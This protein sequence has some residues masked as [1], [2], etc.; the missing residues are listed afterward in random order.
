MQIAY[1]D[2]DRTP[3]LYLLKEAASKHEGLE[4]EFVQVQGGAEYERRFL[5][6]DFDLIC[7][8]LRF[9]F[10]ARLAG[11]PVRCLAAF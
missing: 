8:H 4:I 7:E 6:G 10:P 2:V 1:R 5:A 11:H 3:L 9:L